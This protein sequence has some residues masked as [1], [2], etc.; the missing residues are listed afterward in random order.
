[1]SAETA[2]T[3]YDFSMSGVKCS[4]HTIQQLLSEIRSLLA[5]K[6]DQPRSILCVNAHIFNVAFKVA[7]V[8]ES[9]NN[10]R[11]VTAD[12]MS[13][14]WLSRLWNAVVPERCNMTEAFR[15]FLNCTNMR[16]S[17]AV[18]VGLTQAEAERAMKRI[19]AASKH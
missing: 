19:N 17:T 15:A 14:V 6:F 18:L 16:P 12:G 11:I 13:I 8:R 9:L 2:I 3:P 10:A 1:M 5:H 4:T 7:S